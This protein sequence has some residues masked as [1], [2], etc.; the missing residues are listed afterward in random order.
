[1]ITLNLAVNGQHSLVRSVALTDGGLSNDWQHLTLSQLGGTL[2]L[3]LNEVPVFTDT[4]SIWNQTGFVGIGSMAHSVFFADPQLIELEEPPPLTYEIWAA[5]QLHWPEEL[6]GPADD[7]S[8]NGI[9]NILEFALGASS[10][11]TSIQNYFNTGILDANTFAVVHTLRQDAVVKHL[12]PILLRF[13]NL[14]QCRGS[15]RCIT[16]H[17]LHGRPQH[18]DMDPARP[19]ERTSPVLSPGCLRSGCRGV[20]FAWL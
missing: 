3:Y 7:A 9:A 8:G 10:G 11:S 20:R 15:S 16:H 18:K 12:G 17:N 5:Q 19:N 1:M 14:G 2:T 4:S 6:R 13:G